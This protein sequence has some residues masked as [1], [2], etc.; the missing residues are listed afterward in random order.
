MTSARR[1]RVPLTAVAIALGTVASI[2]GMAYL[3]DLTPFLL[4]AGVLLVDYST[5]RTNWTGAAP[6]FFGKRVPVV[7]FLAALTVTE[8]PLYIVPLLKL[9]P[10]TWAWAHSAGERWWAPYV[11]ALSIASTLA[12]VGFYV[13]AAYDAKR[14][15]AETVASLGD[16]DAEPLG[17]LDGPQNWDNPL[18]IIGQ[19]CGRL[20][21]P[22]SAYGL[23]AIEDVSYATPEEAQDAGHLAPYLTLNIYRSESAPSQSDKLRPVFIYIH[24]GAW[25][26]GLGG[27][28]DRVPIV[29]QMASL[30]WIGVSIDYRLWPDELWPTYVID[31]KRAIRFLKQNIAQYGGDPDMMIVSGGSAGGHLASLLALSGSPD[32]KVAAWQPGFEDVDTSVHGCVAWYPACNTV[33]DRAGAKVEEHWWSKYTGRAFDENLHREASPMHIAKDLRER[34]ADNAPNGWSSFN[35]GDSLAATGIGHRVDIAWTRVMFNGTDRSSSGI[36]S[37]GCP[38]RARFL[39]HEHKSPAKFPYGLTEDDLDEIA[40]ARMQGTSDSLDEAKEVVNTAWEM[41]CDDLVDYWEL[42]ERFPDREDSVRFRFPIIQIYV[43]MLR[44]FCKYGVLS[45]TDRTWFFKIDHDNVLHISNVFRS[46]GTGRESMRYAYTCMVYRTVVGM[47]RL[48]LDEE[49]L[50]AICQTDIRIGSSEWAEVWRR[51]GNG[52][53]AQK[54]ASGGRFGAYGFTIRVDTGGVDMVVKVMT[55]SK[56]L[57]VGLIFWHEMDVYLALRSL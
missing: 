20:Q 55:P 2:A 5:L 18:S 9:A 3:L 33:I 17:R 28:G 4:A 37:P 45:T 47:A 22:H 46:T 43:H 24:G 38:W 36:R 19:W 49:H 30:G 50:R 41:A 11:A 13:R 7:S 44:S 52:G 15:A 10:A 26:R 27:K 54:T 16:D 14:L 56:D 48:A 1:G 42:G 21:M 12:H 31:C 53:G 51:F 8:T 57:H 29:Y 32:S 39:V 40:Q 34:A 6:S 35:I 25:Q 23:E